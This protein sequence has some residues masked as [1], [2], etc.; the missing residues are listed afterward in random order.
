MSQQ[1]LGSLTM[2]I[3]HMVYIES[4]DCL[5]W[6]P[7]SLC[8]HKDPGLQR[9]VDP[10]EPVPQASLVINHGSPQTMDRGH[11][12]GGRWDVPDLLHPSNR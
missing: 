11:R 6:S 4:K 8:R 5:R 12:E 3:C 1:C 7:G 2:F 10:D 9:Q